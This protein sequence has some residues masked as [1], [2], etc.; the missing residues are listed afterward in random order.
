M[1]DSEAPKKVLCAECDSE[2]DLSKNEGVCP[3]CGLDMA[4]IMERRRYDKALR[5]IEKREE[6]ES[7]PPK[8]KRK[9]PFGF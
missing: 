5:R 2:V 4:A 9:K 3:K 8:P 1:P 6:E 7:Q